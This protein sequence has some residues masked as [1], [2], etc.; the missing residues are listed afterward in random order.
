MSDITLV[1][2]NPQSFAL[3]AGQ[4]LSGK[5]V[6]WMAKYR[7]TDDDDDA[8]FTKDSDAVGGVA[9]TDAVGGLATVTLDASD[10]AAYSHG[11]MVWAVQLVAAD[12][13]P[14]EILSGRVIVTTDV[15][16]GGP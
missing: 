1:K 11:S 4:N 6:Q 8:V 3:V 14:T 9:V 2:G 15:I 5:L 13:T 7:A 16:R 12:D 10:W